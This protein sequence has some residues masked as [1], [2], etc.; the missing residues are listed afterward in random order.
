M[1]P[2]AKQ[3]FEIATSLRPRDDYLWLELGT[4]RD[5]LN[6]PAGALK[7]FD[8]A[9]ANA[10]YYA[11]TRWQRA[12]LR[13]R[14]GRYDEAFPEL[15]EAAKSNRNYLP[16]LIDMAWSLSREDAI[17][18]EQLAG[19]DSPD[20][21]VAFARFLA[22]KGKGKETL[23]QYRLTKNYI[24][25]E[26]RRELV[27]QLIGTYAYQ[28][29]F[30]IWKGGELAHDDNEPGVFD[31]GFEG[32]LSFGETGFGWQISREP[33]VG[34]SQDTSDKDSGAKSL[35]ID[36]DGNS[37]TSLP[38]VSQI[39]IAKPGQTYGLN[40]AL[41]T[42]DI[43]TG[44]TP[45]LVIADAKSGVVSKSASLPMDSALWQKQS[46]QFTTPANCE[47]IILKLGRNECQSAPCPIFGTLWLDSFSIE[48][49]RQ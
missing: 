18:T 6:D 30:E 46:I 42:R 48:E 16:P 22:R 21:R 44:G 8:Q 47:A 35:R 34:V 49:M 11:H 31:G 43:V 26:Y 38:I 36:F 1:Y 23:E 2:E 9:V 39:I 41:K 28:E 5:E 17:L 19:I 37:P 10:P 24:S 20:S 27:R 7:A 13:L 15:R 3:E 40:F 14:M 4:I 25:E 12:N 29:A 32:A 45:V 33:M